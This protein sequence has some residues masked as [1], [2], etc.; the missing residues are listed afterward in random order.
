MKVINPNGEKVVTSGDSDRIN[1]LKKLEH[2]SSKKEKI[3]IV[4]AK[5]IIYPESV[6]WKIGFETEKVWKK[7]IKDE[8]VKHQELDFLN[9][10]KD[11][12]VHSYF[13]GLLF[14]IIYIIFEPSTLFFLVIFLPATSL[15]SSILGFYKLKS[16]WDSLINRLKEKL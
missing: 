8:V 10:I 13:L 16:R 15:I 12:F 9:E 3:D 5:S 11:S 14:G 4:K 1:L 7:M 6:N 2:L